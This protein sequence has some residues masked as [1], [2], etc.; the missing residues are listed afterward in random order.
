MASLGGTFLQ[1]TLAAA[2]IGVAGGALAGCGSPLSA[3]LVASPLDPGTLTFWNL[4]GGGDGARLTVMLDQ[5]AQ[6]HGGPASLQAATFS[7]GNPYYTKLSLATLGDKPPDV[8]VSHLTRA[9]NLARANLLT[10]ITDEMLALVGLKPTDFNAEGVG[11]PEA[12]RQV[13]D[14]PLGH[15]PLRHVLQRGRVSEGRPPGCRRQL[16]TDPGDARSSRPP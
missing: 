1:G 2:G 6:E 5:Y 7:W 12:Q 4:F 9:Q 3:G 15:A 10:P 11:G 8:A 14:H 16:E 13:L